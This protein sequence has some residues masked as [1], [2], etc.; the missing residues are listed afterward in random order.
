[1]LNSSGV[2]DKLR[3]ST[4]FVVVNGNT[5]LMCVYGLILYQ[6]LQASL[7]WYIIYR[8]QTERLKFSPGRHLMPHFTNTFRI[9]SEIYYRSLFHILTKWR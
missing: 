6:M 1:M 3:I 2:T 9:V 4:M 7:H 5:M 8:H